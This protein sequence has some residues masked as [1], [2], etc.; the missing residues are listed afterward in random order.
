MRAAEFVESYF[1]AW[2]H[3]D[4][5][6]VADHLAANG[7]YRD[8]PENAQRSHDELITSLSDF[9]STNRHQYELIGEI[10][11]GTNTIAYQY[12]INLFD[13]TGDTETPRSYN[14]A[15]FMMLHGDA[16]VTI[17]DYYDSPGKN[18]PTELARVTKGQAQ[19]HK[20]AKSGLSDEQLLEY[21]HRLNNIMEA[22]KVY[23]RSD[24]TLPALA[25]IVDCSAN[26]LSQ[27]INSG[28]G[29]SFFDFLNRHRIEHAQQLLTTRNIKDSSILNIAFTVGFNSNSAFYAAFKRC[30]GQTPAQFRRSQMRQ[31]K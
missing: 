20:Y 21:K 29:M 30:V 13:G 25:E 27:V 23:L 9:F 4:P 3:R 26:H 19:N 6:G 16:A 11:T 2:N 8:I 10:L 22:Q 12:R 24:V 28:F 5:K 31:P 1:D 15:E 17:T 14:G 7:I 18:R